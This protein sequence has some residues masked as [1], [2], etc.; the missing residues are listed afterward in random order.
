MYY[1]FYNWK[2]F[3]VVGLPT[4]HQIFLPKFKNILIM[5]IDKDKINAKELK[6]KDAGSFDKITNSLKWQ[7]KTHTLAGTLHVL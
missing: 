6:L 2:R 5:N 4:G 3:P 1:K 7:L